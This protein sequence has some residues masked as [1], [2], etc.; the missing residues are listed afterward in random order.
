MSR[1][2]AEFGPRVRRLV[3]RRRWSSPPLPTHSAVLFAG[4]VL[5]V[6]VTTVAYRAG[7]FGIDEVAASPDQLASGK[8]WLLFSSGLL[9]QKPLALSLISFA[10]LGLLTLRLCGGFVLSVTALLGHVSSTLVAYGVLAVIR[11]ISPETFHGIWT[12]PDYGVSAIAAAWLGAVA[13]VLW[14]RRRPTVA[15]RAPVV[16]FCL[17]VAAVGWL[18]RGHLNV[19]DTEHVI[20]FGIGV[21]VS[22]RVVAVATPTVGRPPGSHRQ[23]AV[24]FVSRTRES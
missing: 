23:A 17:A 11:D 12:A 2:V 20:A 9:V 10:A 4:F 13:S 8:V 5:V 19:L 16:F 6:S 1:E 14:R 22:G 21:A 3:D 18:V 7:W 24:A 15:G